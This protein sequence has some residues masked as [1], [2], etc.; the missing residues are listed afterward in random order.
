MMLMVLKIDN[1]KTSILINEES[2]ASIIVSV[3]TSPSANWPTKVFVFTYNSKE[4][5][6]L[7]VFWPLLSTMRDWLSHAQYDAH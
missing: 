7:T 6:P 2:S 1:P 3:P 5:T 4:P